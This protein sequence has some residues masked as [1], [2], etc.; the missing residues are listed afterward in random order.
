[1]STE[2]E[3]HPK[4]IKTVDNFPAIQPGTQVRLVN[5]PAHPGLEGVVATVLSIDE[6]NFVEVEIRKTSIVKK[7]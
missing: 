3:N 2:N 4:R 7:V 6:D 5:L 1:M